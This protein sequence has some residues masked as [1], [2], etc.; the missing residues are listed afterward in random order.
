MKFPDHWSEKDIDQCVNTSFEPLLKE[1]GEICTTI[2]KNIDMGIAFNKV[3]IYGL[4]GKISALIGVLKGI[5]LM[6]KS[7]PTGLE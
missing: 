3:P 1:L 4:S 7:F 6:R 5:E 2:G